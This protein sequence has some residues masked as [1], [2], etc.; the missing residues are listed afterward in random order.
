MKECRI[1]FE[2][3][4]LEPVSFF[5]EGEGDNYIVKKGVKIKNETL[6]IIGAR[7]QKQIFDKIRNYFYHF[8]IKDIELINQTED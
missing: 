5:M 2:N 8:S 6:N 1:Y 7:T 4:K 3:D